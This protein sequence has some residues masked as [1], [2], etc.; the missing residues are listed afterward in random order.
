[1]AGSGQLVRGWTWQRYVQ[2]TKSCKPRSLLA[3]TTK[4]PGMTGMS[5]SMHCLAQVLGIV[6]GGRG[7]GGRGEG[8]SRVWAVQHA[9]LLPFEDMLVELLL[10]A[11]IGQIDTQ[12]LKAVLFEALK[13]VDVQDA[14]SAL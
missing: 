1:M 2:I 11:L 3:S 13:A 8:R 7:G 4:Q 10:Q 12:L 9:Y 6:G 5:I 14:N